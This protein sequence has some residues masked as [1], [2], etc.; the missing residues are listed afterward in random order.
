M[1]KLNI[2][3]DR[4]LEEFDSTQPD[5]EKLIHFS[6]NFPQLLNKHGN[7]IKQGISMLKWIR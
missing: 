2:S 3:L 5:P 1:M 7:S 4:L 6:K